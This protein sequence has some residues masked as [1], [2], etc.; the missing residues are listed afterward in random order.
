[1]EYGFVKVGA[2]IPQLRVADCSYNVT[3]M[4]SIVAEAEKKG[5]EILLFPELGITSCS[6]GDLYRQPTLLN[7]A[8]KALHTLA[9]ETEKSDIIIIVGAPIATGATLFNCAVVLWHGKVMGVVPQYYIPNSGTGA[10]K[11]VFDTGAELSQGTTVDICGEQIEI[12]KRQLFTTPAYTFAIEM[13]SD[14]KAPIS[15]SSI[16]SLQGA[17]MI[18]CLAAD[19]E[20]AESH[21]NTKAMCQSQSARCA[22]GYIYAGCGYGEA[23]GDAVYTGNAFIAENGKTLAQSERF[24]YTGQLIVSDIDVEKIRHERM[25]NSLFADASKEYGCTETATANIPQET[26]KSTEFARTFSQHPFIPE[27]EKLAE[28]CDEIFNIQAAG[29]AKRIEH[30]HAATCVIGISGGLDS[31]L[32]ILVTA[33]AFDKIGKS[34]KDIVAITMPGFGTTDRTYNNALTLMQTLG[35]TIREISIKEACLQ[36]FKDIEHSIDTHDVTYENAQA[37]E[38]TQI[39]M[40]VANKLNGLVVGTGDLSELA[41]GWATYNGDHMSMYSVNATVP[42]TLIKHI[43]RHIAINSDNEATRTTLLDII[44]TPISPELIPADDKGNIKQKTEDLVGPY[45]LH[46]FFLYHIVRNAYSPAKIYALAQ[47]SFEGI[48]DKETIKKWLTTFCRRFFIQQFKRSCM[49]D[50]VKVG[51]VSLS[52]RGDWAMP[53]DACYTLWA[54]ECEALQ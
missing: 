30:T 54:A 12:R 6:C 35:V 49:P 33:A 16:L 22:G 39:L 24:A 4:L 46:D 28:R 2:A 47:K 9:R 1:M 44:D 25:R 10:T 20:T 45:E 32:A 27:G 5:V 11:R 18:F 17:E 40:D 23:S 41:L 26:K 52:P 38:R 51:S 19:N 43:V 31:T 7:G 37:R 50:G 13:S 21:N 15:P 36:H 42:K 48:Y 29:L 8:E 14:L 34:R 3:E 53:T